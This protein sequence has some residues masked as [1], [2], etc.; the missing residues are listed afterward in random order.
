MKDKEYIE[1][2]LV[3]QLMCLEDQTSDST[4][5]DIIEQILIYANLLELNIEHLSNDMF[6]QLLSAKYLKSEDYAPLREIV[7]SQLM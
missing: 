5:K 7:I 3:Y 1:I 4:P 2:Q 6:I